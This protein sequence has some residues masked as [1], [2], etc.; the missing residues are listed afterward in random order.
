MHENLFWGNDLSLLC[1][2]TFQNIKTAKQRQQ[3][4][5]RKIE[6]LPNLVSFGW[7]ILYEI[8]KHMI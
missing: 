4:R 3:K 8:R 2:A 5:E 1:H 6:I 7:L